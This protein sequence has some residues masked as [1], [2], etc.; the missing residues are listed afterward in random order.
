MR[1]ALLACASWAAVLLLPHHRALL[2]PASAVLVA[3]TALL[4]SWL[5]DAR[6]RR[7]V[8]GLPLYLPASLARL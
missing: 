8:H 6:A 1:V 3:C 5:G 4:G 7:C 2:G